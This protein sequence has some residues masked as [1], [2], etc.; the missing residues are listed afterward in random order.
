MAKEKKVNISSSN[1]DGLRAL[2]KIYKDQPGNESASCDDFVQFLSVTSPDST[3]FL[4]AYC[5]WEAVDM[6]VTV[7]IKVDPK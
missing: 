2:Y 1:A 4:D 3:I 6:G 5:D 7:V